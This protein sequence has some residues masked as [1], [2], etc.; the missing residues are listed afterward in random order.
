MWQS[1]FSYFNRYSFSYFSIIL[2]YVT[3][4]GSVYMCGRLDAKSDDVSNADALTQI[5]EKAT[6]VGAKEFITVID[7]M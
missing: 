2:S 4:D 5:D 3:D 6:N 7:R 1:A